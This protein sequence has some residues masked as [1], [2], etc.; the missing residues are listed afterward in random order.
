MRETFAFSP[1]FQ[2]HSATRFRSSKYWNKLSP[3]YKHIFD[4]TVEVLPFR[5]ND[6]VLENLVD[7]DRWDD[8]P[9]FRLMFPQA[10]MLSEGQF[11]RV[12][13]A[14]KVGSAALKAAVARVRHELNPH[15]AGQTTHNIPMFEG[16]AVD[17]VQHKYQ[18]TA[19]F[20]PSSGQ[21]CHAYCSFCFRWP[22]FTA[23]AMHRI[24]AREIDTFTAYLRNHPHVTDVLFTGGDPMVM[25]ARLLERYVAAILAIP[26]VRNIRIGSKAL[27]YW[28]TRFTSDKDAK[29][30]LRVFERIIASGRHVAFMAHLNHWRELMPGAVHEAVSAVRSTGAIIRTQGP[31][32]RHIN[33]DSAV[34]ARL[35]SDCVNLGIIPYYLFVER[36]TGPNAY[37]RIP[38][39]QAHTIYRRAYR[40]VSGLARSARGPVM[41]TLPGKI[42]VEGVLGQGDERVFVLKLLQARNS[43]LVQ[44]LFTASYSDTAAWIDELR[45]HG[46]DRFPFDIAT[47]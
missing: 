46:E 10:G 42:Q 9:M 14:R 18:Q 23:G 26:T 28:P 24:Q 37:F 13:A 44:R 29:A 6:Y 27:S 1:K 8:D 4:T 39:A 12:E 32:L 3:S 19:L 35:W 41:S 11:E 36:D 43:H 45:P 16:N 22:Q 38:L 34:W 21:T 33:D 7:W 15:P 31:L 25:N 30:L 40:S 20:F 47:E 5:V 2:A 17:G